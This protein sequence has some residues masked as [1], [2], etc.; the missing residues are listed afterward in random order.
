[1]AT[2]SR[3]QTVRLWDV[4]TRSPIG[5]PLT[6]H[7]NVV[8]AVAFSPDGRLLATGSADATVRLWEVVR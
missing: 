4:A 6:D 8:G 2:G 1:M 7:T 5:G 3:D